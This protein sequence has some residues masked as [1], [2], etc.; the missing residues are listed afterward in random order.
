MCVFSK[1]ER[2]N[3]FSIHQQN[4]EFFFSLH[5]HTWLYSLTENIMMWKKWLNVSGY[6]VSEHLL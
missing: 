6:C 1:R 2:D 3:Y 4:N 5:I